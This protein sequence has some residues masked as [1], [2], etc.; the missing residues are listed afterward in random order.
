MGDT[1]KWKNVCINKGDFRERKECF[2]KN[3]HTCRLFSN[4]QSMKMNYCPTCGKII[5]VI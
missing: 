5:E 2:I 4:E 3:P 1:C